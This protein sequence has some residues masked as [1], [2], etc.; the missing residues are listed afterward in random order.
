MSEILLSIKPMFV[1]NIIEGK[2]L[3]EYRKQIPKEKVDK[4]YVYEST[5]KGRK[6]VV[7]EMLI[8]GILKMS[9][10]ELW[11]KT[12]GYSGISQEF[13]NEYFDGKDI[14]YAYSIKNV[15]TKGYP[16]NLSDFGIKHAPENYCYIKS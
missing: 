1:K 15:S 2:K 11:N 8:D 16:K 3:Y 7:A 13:F 12:S 14:A 10:Q 4:I 9:P 5:P 6:Q